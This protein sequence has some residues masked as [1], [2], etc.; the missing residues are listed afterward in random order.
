MKE[1]PWMS[2]W[3]NPPAIQ[4][5]AKRSYSNEIREKLRK[6][7]WQELESL[8]VFSGSGFRLGRQDR[9]FALWINKH[10]SV[11]TNHGFVLS[12]D[13]TPPSVND[14]VY[15]PLYVAASC[16]TPEPIKKVYAEKGYY[17]KPSSVFLCR[18]GI[19]DVTNRR[20][21]RSTKLTDY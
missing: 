20:H 15:L 5:A 18:Y 13:L 10:A 9:R 19:A 16:H 3:F 4:S 1:L 6:A 11:D 21:T 14:N 17:E 8:I 12:T 2:A 7:N